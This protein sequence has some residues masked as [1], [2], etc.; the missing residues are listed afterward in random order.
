[1]EKAQKG[2]RK[3]STQPLLRLTWQRRQVVITTEYLMRR[4]QLEPLGIERGFFRRSY[5]ASETIPRSALPDRFQN[6]KPFCT[7][8]YYLTTPE[9]HSLLHRL[10][11]DE[12][13]HYYIGDPLTLLL[14]FPDGSH[15]VRTLGHDLEAGHELQVVVPRDT[16]QGSMLQ[17]GGKYAL[18][19][20]SMAP[21]FDPSDFELGDRKMLQA[22]YPAVA[23]LIAAMTPD[24]PPGTP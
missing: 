10:L 18:L 2:L 20:A 21:G 13:L 1:M 8:I 22:Q 23:D 12:I 4:F 6:D 15:Q 9:S 14:L 3:A 5:T 16:W 7:C 17:P 24:D 19:G 11:T